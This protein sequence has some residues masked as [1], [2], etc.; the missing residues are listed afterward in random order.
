MINKYF[1]Y[2]I[3]Q[4]VFEHD[5]TTMNYLMRQANNTLDS[6][7]TKIFAV[8]KSWPAQWILSGNRE[9]RNSSTLNCYCS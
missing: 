7:L 9:V 2:N 4:R 6:F 5:S 3:P 8:W 1:T